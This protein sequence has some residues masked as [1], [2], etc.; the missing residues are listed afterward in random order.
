MIC[1]RGKRGHFRDCFGNGRSHKYPQSRA[2]QYGKGI[3]AQQ[4]YSGSYGSFATFSRTVDSDHFRSTT[5]TS[6]QVVC[7]L[8]S[9]INHLITSHLWYLNRSG[10]IFSVILCQMKSLLGRY[11]ALT[12]WSAGPRLW[13][14]GFIHP[15]S[16]NRL[17][18]PSSR[19]SPASK[20]L[21]LS[22]G[23]GIR[24][25][26]ITP[27]LS[28]SQTQSLKVMEEPTLSLDTGQTSM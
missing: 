1:K 10:S 25:P 22:W 15:D 11:M 17:D 23:G 8:L 28:Q 20:T 16:R 3:V 2:C 18:F 5:W 27:T 7:D 19:R 21:I 9:S 4:R 24:R 14:A 12:A 26:L 6:L 13:P